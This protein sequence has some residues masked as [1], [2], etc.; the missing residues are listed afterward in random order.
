MLEEDTRHSLSIERYFATEEELKA[1]LQGKKHTQKF[2]IITEHLNL[3][4]I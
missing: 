1:V 4:M 3:S 2:L